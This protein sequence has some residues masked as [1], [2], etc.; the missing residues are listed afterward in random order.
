MIHVIALRWG[1]PCALIAIVS[2]A[3]L[4]AQA[5]DSLVIS[6]RMEIQVRRSADSTWKTA[7]TGGIFN[8]QRSCVMVKLEADDASG[9][10][11]LTSFKAFAGVRVKGRN[12]EWQEISAAELTR[13][14]HCSLE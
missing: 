3:P 12:G 7:T 1:L 9:D 10:Y 13:L 2:T 14:Q 8:A 4:S 11:I 5:S 6:T